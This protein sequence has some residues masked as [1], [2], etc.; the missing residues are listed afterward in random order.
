MGKK[1]PYRTLRYFIF[2]IIILVVLACVIPFF[3]KGPDNQALI[4]PDQIKLPKLEITQKTDQDPRPQVASSQTSPEGK[5]RKVYK[6][7]DK[8]G[9]WH[10]TDYPNPNG[11]SQ[12][13]YV[14]PDKAGKKSEAA[15][16]PPV[17]DT[18][19]DDD[20]S[21]GISFP[22]IVSPSELNKLKQEAE[23]LKKELEKRYEELKQMTF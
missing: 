23:A 20:L 6:W 12:V 18:N 14:S 16:K 21:S 3:I 13:I 2:S 19:D 11:P 7:K 17:S 9:V 4:S 1:Q 5:Y 15:K 10:F 8:D 22:L